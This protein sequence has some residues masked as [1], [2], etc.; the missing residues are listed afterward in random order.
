MKARLGGSAAFTLVEL[1]LT[2]VVITAGLFGLLTVFEAANRGALYGQIAQAAVY[3]ARERLEVITADKAYRGYDY[4]DAAHYPS[5]ETVMLGEHP[6]TRLVNIA[7]VDPADLAAPLAASGYKRI[8][9]AVSWGVGA[10]NQ[11]T[12]SAILGRY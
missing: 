8:D 2:M 9:V 7:E 11:V 4:I 6:Y 10:A 5:A 3:L 12:L 1:I